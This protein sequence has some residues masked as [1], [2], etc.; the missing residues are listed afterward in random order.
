VTC[1]EDTGG[2][3]DVNSVFKVAMKPADG[4]VSFSAP[5]VA[6][7]TSAGRMHLNGCC[8]LCSVVLVIHGDA[9]CC[10]CCG[11]R[12]RVTIV[13]IE[14]LACGLHPIRAC[15]HWVT[16]CEAADRVLNSTAQ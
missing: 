3:I 16:M 9:T 14:L 11:C 8:P 15:T 1:P 4:D 5:R 10:P 12:W 2:E 7:V 13:S 6:T